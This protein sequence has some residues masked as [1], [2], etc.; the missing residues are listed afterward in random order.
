MSHSLFDDGFG[1]HRCCCFFPFVCFRSSVSRG[2]AAYLNARLHL[3][4]VENISFIFISTC[5]DC[6]LG[7][8]LFL[9]WSDYTISSF[10]SHL[11]FFGFSTFHSHHSFIAVLFL[12]VCLFFYQEFSII[13]SQFVDFLMDYLPN[14]TS[15][16]FV[17]IHGV[18]CIF[19]SYFRPF[20]STQWTS[21]EL[22]CG[23]QLLSAHLEFY[24]NIMYYST[25]SFMLMIA[26]KENTYI[27][28]NEGKKT[29]R[30]PS[31]AK[32]SPF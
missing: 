17:T 29:N 31:L 28:S 3:H 7:S 16:G 2:T 19:C 10:L 15:G 4:F 30:L 14:K 32:C 25:H 20:I 6:L 12:D 5:F 24:L 21:I 11:F 8:L 1:H 18:L 27:N 22:V 26:I 13:Y 23:A 9:N